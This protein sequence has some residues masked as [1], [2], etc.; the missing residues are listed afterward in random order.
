MRDEPLYVQVKRVLQPGDRPRTA[1]E[2]AAQF[3]R[4]EV[5][6]ERVLEWMANVETPPSMREI[7]NSSPKQWVRR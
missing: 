1:Q 6:A 5:Q 2:I 4:S 3:E 7:P